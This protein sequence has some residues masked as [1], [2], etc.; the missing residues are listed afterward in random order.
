MNY[1]KNFIKSILAGIM[2]S[3]GA[4]ISLRANLL[5]Q[6][7]IIGAFL[8]TFGLIVICNFDYNLFTGKICYILDK[9]GK[10]IQNKIVDI[11]IIIFGNMIG[12]YLFSL[13]LKKSIVYNST[14]LKIIENLQMTVYNKINYEWYQMIGLSFFCGILINIAVEGFKKINNPFGKYVVLILAVVGFILCGFE[15]SVANMFYYFFAGYFSI[16][17]F[18]SLLLCIIGN[19]LGGIFIPILN[20]ILLFKSN[21][22]DL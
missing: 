21:N 19:T 22:S 2:V 12:C 11:F 7:N 5:A 4:F 18:L 3:F 8:F 14:N 16:D 20:K 17:S 6:S 13:I 10:N 9:N 1:I 15:H